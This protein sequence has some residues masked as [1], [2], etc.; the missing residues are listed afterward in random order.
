[1]RFWVTSAVLVSAEATD[2]TLADVAALPGAVEVTP[3]YTVEPLDDTEILPVAEPAVDPES[4][5]TYGI[6]KI[7]AD[8]VWRD[9]DARG[10]G[11]RVA[12]LDTGVDATHPEIAS[13]LVGRDTGDPSYPGG[14]INFDR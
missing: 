3:N 6:E 14:W 8:A 13:R 1:N 11:V 10:Q 5:V 2:R 12:V 9:F 4:P 7:G